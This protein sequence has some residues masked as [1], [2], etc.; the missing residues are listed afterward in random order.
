MVKFQGYWAR[1]LSTNQ[2]DGKGGCMGDSGGAAYFLND[3]GSLILVGATKGP[4]A[5]YSYCNYFVEYS[6]ISTF[7]NFIIKKV[8]ILGGTL[9]NFV[10]PKNSSPFVFDTTVP[11]RMYEELLPLMPKRKKL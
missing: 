6:N 4:L 11:T 7:K 1:H 9:P 10:V 3:D 5:P 2:L 8:I